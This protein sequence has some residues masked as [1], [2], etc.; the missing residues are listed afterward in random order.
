MSN[1]YKSKQL[2]KIEY[3]LTIQLKRNVDLCYVCYTS[4]TIYAYGYIYVELH[5]TRND[6]GYSKPY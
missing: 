3:M 6:T 2:I 5:S 4:P 1:N